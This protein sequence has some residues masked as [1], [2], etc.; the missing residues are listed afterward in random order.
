MMMMMTTIIINQ[1]F[2][3]YLFVYQKLGLTLFETTT[4]KIFH[5]VL[6]H[7]AW[8]E[9]ILVTVNILLLALET[10]TC[11]PPRHG[12]RQKLSFSATQFFAFPATT[13]SELREPYCAYWQR[14]HLACPPHCLCL[15]FA[16]YFTF[17]S[18]LQITRFMSDKFCFSEYNFI[19]LNGRLGTKP[20]VL[21]ILL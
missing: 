16:L 14:N 21:T 5:T 17:V 2:K 7:A 4:F 15:V 18:S 13:H 11:T 6:V 8:V 19:F 10:Y 12:S 3:S 20:Q 1:I 9:F